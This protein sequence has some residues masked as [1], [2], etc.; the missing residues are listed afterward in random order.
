M[1]E[2]GLIESG[3]RLP[4]STLS[5]NFHEVVRQAMRQAGVQFKQS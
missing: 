5:T 4:L 2:M 3:L 1:V